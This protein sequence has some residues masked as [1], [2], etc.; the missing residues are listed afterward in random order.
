AEVANGH[1]FQIRGTDED[2][3]I[4]VWRGR[5]PDVG[6]KMHTVAHGDA[7]VELRPERALGAGTGSGYEKRNDDERAS[8]ATRKTGGKVT[9]HVFLPIVLARNLAFLGSR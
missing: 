3:R 6:G 5:E 8:G 9:K 2:G 7:R 4:A 1:R